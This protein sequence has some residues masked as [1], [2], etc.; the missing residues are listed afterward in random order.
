MY[1][2]CNENSVFY[3]RKCRVFAK[4]RAGRELRTGRKY[5][6][7]KTFL[8]VVRISLRERGTSCTRIYVRIFC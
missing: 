5:M 6:M 4:R 7:I 8:F 2:I 3:G 1:M